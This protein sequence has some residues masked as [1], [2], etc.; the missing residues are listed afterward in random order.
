MAN[1]PVPDTT[2][3]LLPDGE[4]LTGQHVTLSRT[5]AEHLPDLYENLSRHTS[6]WTYLPDGPFPTYTSFTDWL[7]TLIPITP[8]LAVYTILVDDQP[9]GI[10]SLFSAHL[11]NRVIELGILFGPALQRTRAGTEAVFLVCQLIFEK[12]GYRRLEW[13]CDSVNL[14]SWRAAERYGFVHEGTLRQHQIIKGRNRDSCWFSIVDSDW[15]LLARAFE[16]WLEDA[17]F[18][19]EQRQKRTLVEVRE[20]L[21]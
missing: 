16:A 18:D 9:V 12:L 21:R 17:N 8:S 20:G 1:P 2:P 10:V 15:P 4:T 13:K 6:T 11:T 3:A 7:T 19:G 14:V 5:T